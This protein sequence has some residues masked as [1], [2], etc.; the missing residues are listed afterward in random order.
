MDAWFWCLVVFGYGAIVGSFLNVLIYRMPLGLSVSSPPS[1]CPRC[2]TKLGFWDNVPLL[3]FLYLGARCRYCHIPITWR[4]FTVELLTASLWVCLYL[5]ISGDTGISWV[6]Y[7]AQA[8]FASLLVAV[9]FIDLDHFIIPDELNQ[10]GFVIGVGR[11]VVC[12][13]L[14]WA[15][16]SWMW[17]ETLSQFTFRGWL[18]LSLPGAAVYGGALFLVS[19]LGYLYYAREPGETVGQTARRFFIYDEEAGGD[20]STTEDTERAEEEG[21]SVEEGDPPRL[22]FSPAFLTALASLLLFTGIGFWAVGVFAAVTAAFVAMSRGAG[23]SR[24]ET[25]ARFFRADDQA[26]VWK[27]EPITEETAA[28]EEESGGEGAPASPAQMAAEADQFAREAETGAHGAMGLGDVKLAL[29]IGA[30]LGPALALLSLFVAM[31]TGAIVGVSMAVISRKGLRLGIPFGPF[32]AF[33][34]ILVMLY[35]QNFLG[36]Y[37]SFYTQTPVSVS[38]PGPRRPAHRPHHPLRVS[39]SHP[40]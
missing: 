15:T 17:R 19:F 22:H 5:R 36:W 30:I 1:H 9:T 12:L 39:P 34:A 20:S 24:G 27:D 38:E 11:D 6:N 32:M 2:G 7:I 35:G 29:A 13:A 4:Y 40:R 21:E 28:E 18:P 25:L 23:E 31:A 26:G 14:A 8:L 37:L 10:M 3:S 16:A 33:G